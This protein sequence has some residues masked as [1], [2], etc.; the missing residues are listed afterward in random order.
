MLAPSHFLIRYRRKI[1]QAALFVYVLNPLMVTAQ[2]I[3]NAGTANDGRRTFVDQT[4]SGV[5]KVNITSPNAAGVSHNSYQQFDV[6]KTGVVLNNS[7]LNSNTR[8]AGWVEGNP[9]LRP[10]QAA[11]LILNE[12]VGGKASQLQGYLEV[13]GQKADVIVANE[14]GITCNGCG[15]INTDRATLSTGKPVF[16]ADGALQHMRVQ[17]GQVTVGPDGLQA[18][19]TRV[20]I[21]SSYANIQ[22]SIHAA[23][24]QT[25]VGQ[26]DIDYAG[27][28]VTK[29]P[30]AQ[31]STAANTSAPPTGL[32]VSALGGMYA[33]QI[34][35]VA[36]GEGVGVKIDGKLLSAGQ[37]SIQSDGTLTHKGNTQGDAGVQLQAQRLEQAGQVRS[38]QTV[39]IQ[40]AQLSHSGTTQGKQLDIAVSGDA[41][42]SGHLKALEAGLH[43]QVGG[44]LRN[45][46]GAEILSQSRV[47]INAAQALNAGLIEAGQV[48][49]KT[50]ADLINQGQVKAQKGGLVLE[51]G[52]ALANQKTASIVSQ[53]TAQV[54]A[55][56]LSNDGTVQAT[57]LGLQTSG[58]ATNRG[59]IT[60]G[61][62][63]LQM[64]IGGALRNDEGGVILSQSAAQLS[65]KL[66]AN[67]GDIITTDK[68]TINASD[69]A[70]TGVIRSESTL[71]IRQAQTL[72]NSGTLAAKLIALQ[73]VATHN[74]GSIEAQSLTL[75]G[76]VGTTPDAPSELDNSG[77][78]AA[79]NIRLTD[80]SEIDNSGKITTW[81]E[82]ASKGQDLFIQTQGLNNAGGD[83]KSVV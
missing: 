11:K 36:T 43:M 78:M 9:N 68:T 3:V 7:G 71:E 8:I 27:G 44:V 1:A 51:A 41:S 20:D 24:I 83:R 38:A 64:Q 77:V 31:A 13:A 72:D 29:Q 5:A 49:L 32:D 80:L 52:G 65:A 50:S 58:D 16:G 18:A 33:N 26:N 53:S 75:T 10:E 2:V 62:D 69:V 66:L 63:N 37:I 82:G 57:K 34:S 42:N 74:S 67:G 56:S 22:G 23:K 59:R 12:V 79:Q 35:L 81:A 17:Q 61:T 54:T 25:V 70:N 4:Q 73:A 6:P 28:Q 39:N 45:A 60:A 15:F 48:S 46:T 30:T 76:D 55:K 19:D 21:L 47:Q 14:H 40:A